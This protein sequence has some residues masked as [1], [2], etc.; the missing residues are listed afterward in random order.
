MTVGVDA[1]RLLKAGVAQH[2][3]HQIAALVH[4]A[5][6]RGE[7]WVLHPFLEPSDALVVALL[8]LGLDA[9]QG[10]VGEERLDGLSHG[11]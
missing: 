2:P 5:I 9:P 7:G 3:H 8:D 11:W 10:R 4:A 6:L 1:C